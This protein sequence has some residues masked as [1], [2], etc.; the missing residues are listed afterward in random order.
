MKYVVTGSGGVLGGHITELLNSNDS[1]VVEISSRSI[2]DQPSYSSNVEKCR[3]HPNDLLS[4]EAVEACADADALI[5]CAFP[6]TENISDLSKALEYTSNVLKLINRSG[7]RRLINISSQS[8]YSKYRTT[9]ADEETPPCPGSMYGFAKR[10]VELMVEHGSGKPCSSIR[11]AS[12]IGTDFP[13]RAINKMV[14]NAINNHVIDIACPNQIFEYMDVRDAAAAIVALSQQ[15]ISTESYYVL[16]SGEHVTLLEI[17]LQIKATT[18][19]IL[20]INVDLRVGDNVGNKVCNSTLNSNLF[21]KKVNWR[22]RYR[23]A[24]TILDLLKSH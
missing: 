15:Q 13:E 20:G 14:S 12:L 8:V 17:G 4:K 21:Y 7:I 18:Q 9:P 10:A 5:H 19:E 11:L 1:K 23:I 6:R 16:G 24:D 3:I 2:S 22:P